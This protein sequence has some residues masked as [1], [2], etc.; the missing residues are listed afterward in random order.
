MIVCMVVVSVLIV[1]VA[2]HILFPV[3]EVAGNSMYPTYKDGEFLLS[4]RLHKISVGD[5]VVFVPPST[6]NREVEFV[7]KR[8]CEIDKDGRIFFMGDNRDCS[9]DSRDYGYVD[10]NMVVARIIDQRVRGR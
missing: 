7:I 10:P 1:L 5:V 3:V 4:S 8:A 6:P 2:L 9:Y